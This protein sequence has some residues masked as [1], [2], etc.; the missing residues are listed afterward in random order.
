M[1]TRNF[2]ERHARTQPAWFYRFDYAHPIAGATHGLDLT[3]MWPMSGIKAALARG[4]WMSGRRAA[5]AQRMRAHVAAFV[6]EADPGADWPRFE[7]PRF[8]TKIYALTD[9]VV[10]D[11]DADRR[12][13]WGGE[14]ASPGATLPAA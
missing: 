6:R 10:D 1:P 5:L 12:R 4:G 9:S 13:A 2:A 11:P 14:G 7:A 8:A 3:F